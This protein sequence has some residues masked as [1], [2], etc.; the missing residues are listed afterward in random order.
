MVVLD[1]IWLGWLGRPIYLK[2]IGHLMRPEADMGYAA[3]FYALYIISIFVSCVL[4]V[5]RVR[6]S[7]MRGAFMGFY[8]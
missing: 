5:T 3:L 8:A 4:M 2:H 6:Q 1:L 7:A